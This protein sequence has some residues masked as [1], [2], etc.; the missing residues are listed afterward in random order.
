[1]NIAIT[2]IMLYVVIIRRATI[3]TVTE[4]LGQYTPKGIITHRLTNFTPYRVYFYIILLY[5]YPKG[6]NHAA[7]NLIQIRQSHAQ[8]IRPD[9]GGPLGEVRSRP[10]LCPGAGAGQTDSPTGQ[11]QLDSQPIR[12]RSR[13]SPSLQK[14]R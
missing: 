11:S 5:L 7:N 14:H 12:Q 9:S 13:R 10:A 8:A 2:R 1:M 6:Y 4:Y 3:L